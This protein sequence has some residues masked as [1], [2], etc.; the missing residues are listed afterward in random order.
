MPR[1][2]VLLL[3]ACA[4]F[5]SRAQFKNDNVLFKTVYIDDLCAAMKKNPGY[6]LLDVRSRGEYDDTSQYY[7]LNIGHLKGAV[8]MSI[9]RLPSEWRSLDIQK[10]QPVFVYCSHSQRSRRA[11]KMLV[12]SGFTHVINVNGAMTE[13]NLIRHSTDPCVGALYQT[14]NAFQVLSPGEV[15]HLIAS[16]SDLFILD[17]RSDSAFRGLAPTSGINAFGKFKGSVN[18]PRDS[19]AAQRGRIPMHR[20][21]LVVDDFGGDAASAVAWLSANGFTRLHLAFNGLERWAEMSEKQL[22]GRERYWIPPHGI[23]LLSPDDMAAKLAKDPDMLLID[24]RT[25]A[26]FNNESKKTWQNVGHLE[27]SVNVPAEGFEQ[28]VDEFQPD[29]YKDI[30]VYGF[31]SSADAFAAARTLVANGYGKVNVLVGGIWDVRWK[32]ANEKQEAHL[33]KWVV[34]DPN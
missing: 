14:A 23:H 21:V 3:F 11:S 24:I 6:F 4:C 18:I 26:E 5:T 9:D 22:P 1:L 34:D 10:D 20:P 2:T 32:A 13:Y 30:L 15:A 27:G 16:N 31:S 17:V 19:L 33:K 12:D 29:K 8:N 25:A 7:G 28:H